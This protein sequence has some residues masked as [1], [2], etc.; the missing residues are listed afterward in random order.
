MSNHFSADNLEFP[1]DDARLDLTDLYVFQAPADPGTTVLIINVNPFMTA[2]AFHPDAVW[3][4]SPLAHVAAAVRV[5]SALGPQATTN[6]TNVNHTT[7][8]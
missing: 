4:G 2:P 3:T 6:A 7:R 1:G 8:R 5:Q